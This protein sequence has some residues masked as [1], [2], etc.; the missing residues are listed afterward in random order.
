MSGKRGSGGM[1]FSFKSLE[2]EEEDEEDLTSVTGEF[3]KQVSLKRS[4]TADDKAGLTVN[5]AKT[6]EESKPPKLQAPS[7]SLEDDKISSLTSKFRN[8]FTDI[9]AKVVKKIEDIS[10]ELSASPDEADKTLSEKVAGNMDNELPPGLYNIESQV[11]VNVQKVEN[12]AADSN[13]GRTDSNVGRERSRSS[14]NDDF[15]MV[16]DFYE[17][18]D[19]GSFSYKLFVTGDP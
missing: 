18:E 4:A 12:S 5:V 1:K 19:P 2:E 6:S 8:N 7:K 3:D 10:N 11:D 9:K 13:R 17:S 16:D 14:S 15:Q